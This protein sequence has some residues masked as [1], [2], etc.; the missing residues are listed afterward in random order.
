MDEHLPKAVRALYVYHERYAG[1]Q[2]NLLAS[3]IL[4][5]SKGGESEE[6]KGSVFRLAAAQM[7]RMHR[8]E[9]QPSK[10]GNGDEGK[11][12]VVG[13]FQEFWSFKAF[14]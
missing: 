5:D 11:G 8:G 9:V 1:L 4:K 12:E 7:V 10:Y 3:G 6:E 14:F 13:A 2:P